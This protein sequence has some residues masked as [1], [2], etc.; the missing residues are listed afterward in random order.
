MLEKST[1]HCVPGSGL[2]REN[3]LAVL[4]PCF[5]RNTRMSGDVLG[6]RSDPMQAF[7]INQERRVGC[8]GKLVGIGELVEELNQ[9]LLSSRME[10]QTRLVEQENRVLMSTVRLNK[11][12]EVK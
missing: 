6:D 3:G 1:N 12:D 7:A 10:V 5:R 9:F 11:K 4:R 2:K 8:V